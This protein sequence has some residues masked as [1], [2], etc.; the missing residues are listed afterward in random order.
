MRDAA[1]TA[2]GLAVVAVVA[3][4]ALWLAHRVIARVIG[5]AMRLGLDNDPADELA[6]TELRKRRATV[7]ALALAVVRVIIVILAA[8]AALVVVFP[9]IDF[10]PVIAALG[11]VGAGLAIALRDVIGDYLAGVF[12]LAE[13][14]YAV[15]DIV[16]LA[17]I[18]GT[19]ED[20]GLRRTVLRDIN[21][22]VHT[23]SNGAIRV[24]SNMTRV[25]NRVNL[26][27]T[28][29]YGTD[30]DRVTGVVDEVGRQMAGDPAWSGGILE[31]PHVARV[32]ALVETGVTLKVLGTVR[33]ADRWALAGELRKRI[34]AAFEQ[35]G[36]LLA[37][38]QQQYAAPGPTSPPAG[39]RGGAGR[40][41]SPS[42]KEPRSATKGT[43]EE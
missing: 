16:E 34:L 38:A 43:N 29:G 7:E 31:A 40:A 1:D 8:V 24:A 30:I 9:A 33:A 27:L 39:A 42:P 3:L 18:Q 25:W 21:G 26:D 11:V 13:N 35:N 36:I 14:Q 6:A 41:R 19:V 22:T 20:F 17:G 32:E 2:I 28:L 15:G 10:A 5:P 12:I 23:V 4:V 37:A